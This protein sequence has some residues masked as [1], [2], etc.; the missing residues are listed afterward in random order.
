KDD[1][2]YATVTGVQ[3]CTLPISLSAAFGAERLRGDENDQVGDVGFLAVRTEQPADDRDVAEQ[4]H[5]G[6]AVGRLG[7][8]ETADAHG[9]PVL[10]RTRDGDGRCGSEDVCGVR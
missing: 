9:E 5:L 10:G 7:G 4:R 2:R 8:D 1:M 3:T 6:D